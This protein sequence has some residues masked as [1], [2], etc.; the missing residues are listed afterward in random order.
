MTTFDRFFARLSLPRALGLAALLWALI[1][2]PVLGSL[3][4]K[5]EEGRRILPAVTMLDSGDWLVPQVGGVPYYSKPPLI[6]WLVAKSF[7]WTGS[8]NEWTARLPS[9]LAMLALAWAA[10][11][12]LARWLGVGGGLLCAIFLLTNIGLMEK[13]RLIEI[14]AVYL[15][16]YGLALLLWLGAWRRDADRPALPR[17]PWRAW[18]L[19]HLFLGLGL[20]TK[21]PLHLVYFYA[22][23]LGILLCAGRWR[24]ALNWAHLLGIVIMLSI[25]ASWAVPYFREINVGQATGRW[26]TQMA[27]RA[28]VSEKF[29]LGAWLLNG[30]R[31]LVNFLPWV[32]LL[33]LVWQLREPKQSAGGSRPPGAMANVAAQP[34]DSLLDAAIAR[35]LCWSLALCFVIISL[36][37]GGIPRYTLPLLVPA[38][39]LLALSFS[40]SQAAAPQRLLPWRPEVAIHLPLVW[41]RVLAVC[42]A[43]AV[44]A[45]PV[46]AFQG[47]RGS[48]RWLT[49]LAVVTVG[50]Y[51]L[52]RVGRLRR[53]AE[54]TA[55][56]PVP[57]VL[58]L[59][60][61]SGAVMA[62]LTADYAVGA[63]HRLHRSE[64][65]RPVGLAVRR[66]VPPGQPVAVLE[67]GFLPFLFY[68]DNLHYLQTAEG[69]PPA[70][71]YLLVR[72]RDLP[73][74]AV[75]LKQQGYAPR[76]LLGS[77]D[78]RISDAERGTWLLLGLDRAGLPSL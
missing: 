31:G 62:L 50:T 67:P 39:I 77:K 65:V 21:G 74:A 28:E 8:R 22:V 49:A 73:A 14:E 76:V 36:A 37:P 15:S 51:L 58:P 7:Q 46:A 55:P 42:L 45:A 78:K 34:P 72:Q 43:L 17:F 44:V 56:T 19:P 48:W 66:V 53:Y 61:A 23:V 2:L 47:G 68:V 24:D 3:E 71:H 6:N 54:S 57:A 25:F 26:Y 69:F 52:R 64:S 10:V 4:I 60:L 18:T 41:T 29:K 1:Y 35:G 20:L 5:G 16:L 75:A 12:S 9:V 59:A 32:V 33:P 70:V 40:Q 30:P 38:S 63:L 27:G 11:W 13:G